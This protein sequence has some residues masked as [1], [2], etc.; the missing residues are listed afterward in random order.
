MR[1]PL[2]R[3]SGRPV[4]AVLVLMAMFAAGTMPVLAGRQS[5]PEQ[6]AKGRGAIESTTTETYYP[7]STICYAGTEPP[8]CPNFDIVATITTTTH[9]RQTFDF[10]ARQ[11]PQDSSLDP[12]DGPSG[13]IKLT[14]ETT[15]TVV[16]ALTGPGEN[17]CNREDLFVLEGCP[18]PGTITTTETITATA[19]V[20]CLTVVQN[21]AAIGGH[22]IR[23]SGETPPTRGVLLNVTDNTVARQQL[24]QDRF[25][26]AYTADVPYTCPAP[27]EA[28]YITEGDIYV[29][30]S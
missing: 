7:V 6:L 19:N 25:V 8:F 24:T 17:F 4:I 22:V 11:G 23:W 12:A 5:G 15:T 3:T 2:N 1:A 29:D 13:R 20:T 28:P 9:V 10:D 21:R 27:V 16:T 26:A 14:Q 30:Q 18:E